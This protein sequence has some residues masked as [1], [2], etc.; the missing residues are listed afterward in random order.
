MILIQVRRAEREERVL[1][2]KFGEEYATY[3]SKT[4]F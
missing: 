3:R 2:E 4:W 1:M